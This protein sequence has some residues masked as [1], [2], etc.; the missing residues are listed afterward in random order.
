MATGRGDAAGEVWGAGRVTMASIWPTA[1]RRRGHRPLARRLRAGV[2]SRGQARFHQRHPIHR[3]RREPALRQRD[4]GAPSTSMRSSVQ[5]SGPFMKWFERRARR[6]SRL[7]SSRSL[8]RIAARQPENSA[9]DGPRAV[10]KQAVDQGRMRAPRSV[11]AIAL[12][13]LAAGAP[14]RPLATRRS[15]R[16]RRLGAEPMPV[17]RVGD[18]QA[19]RRTAA[20]E[21][22]PSGEVGPPGPATAPAAGGLQAGQ[23]RR[24]QA[25]ASAH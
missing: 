20:V 19:G 6:P 8:T 16:T 12:P 25:V 21:V 13:R 9:L 14:D 4:G 24:A 22:L 23:G 10:R 11:A 2:R 1:R 15:R 17:G 5:C 7:P 18:H 3:W